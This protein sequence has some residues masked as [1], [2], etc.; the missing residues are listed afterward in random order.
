MPKAVFPDQHIMNMAVDSERMSTMSR[1]DVPWAG[2]PLTVQRTLTVYQ[3]Y[4][5]CN[6]RCTCRATC[7]K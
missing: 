6:L 5:A 2:I 3:L 7:L 4:L 1:V